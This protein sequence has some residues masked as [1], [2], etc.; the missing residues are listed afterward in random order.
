MLVPVTE[1][2]VKKS[3][4]V[5]VLS[6]KKKFGIHERVNELSSQNQSSSFSVIFYFD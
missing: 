4:K 3:K 6:W 1:E 5:V 2:K